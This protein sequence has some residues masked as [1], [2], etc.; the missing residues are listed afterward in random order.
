MTACSYS[1]NTFL[2]FSAISSTSL[3]MDS[4]EGAMM[5]EASSNQSPCWEFMLSE[6]VGLNGK[7]K[8][9]LIK[10]IRCLAKN[11]VKSK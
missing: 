10:E 1:L 2:M 4:R 3:L 9:R 8:S 7:V 5:V 6:E 11:L